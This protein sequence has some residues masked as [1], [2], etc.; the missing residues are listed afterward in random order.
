MAPTSFINQMY[1]AEMI[2]TTSFS[3]C[4]ERYNGQNLANAGTLTIGG[5]KSDFLTSPMVYLENSGKQG[6]YT[7]FISNIYLRD[8]GGESVSPD[9]SRQR[10]TKLIFDKTAANFGAGT[11]IDTT[12]PGTLLNF[13]I[14]NSFRSEWKK[15]TGKTY[16]TDP[17]SL[18]P[19]ELL[20]LP[21]VLVQLRSSTS[22]NQFTDPD[23]VVGMVGTNLDPVSI[24]IIDANCVAYVLCVLNVII[25]V[26]Y[27]NPLSTCF[28]LYPQHTTCIDKIM[29]H[30]K[31]CYLLITT[32]AL[33]WA[34]MY[35]KGDIYF[36]EQVIVL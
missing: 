28:W 6:K 20:G 19:T 15:M 36:S 9:D 34:Q 24:R 12:Y 1:R 10:V 22:S 32:M 7:T 23:T 29:G 3:L 26:V 11:V 16:T 27:S 4:F 18:T 31:L 8:G 13:S 14:G 5:Y 33:Y 25:L 30:T 21:T 17:I 35:F 2:S